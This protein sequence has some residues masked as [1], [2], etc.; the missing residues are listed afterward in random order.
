MMRTAISEGGECGVEL[1]GAMPM[2][3]IVAAAPIE[4]RQTV[5]FAPKP[6]TIAPPKKE[7]PVAKVDAVKE[8]AK[9][10]PPVEEL[11]L[12]ERARERVRSRREQRARSE[13]PQPP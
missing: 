3:P 9:A 2:A 5:S 7:A 8:R 4:Q 11:A 6:K 12:A 1:G 13:A 10:K